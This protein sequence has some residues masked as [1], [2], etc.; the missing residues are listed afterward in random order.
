MIRKATETDIPR[1]AEIYDKT[2]DADRNSTSS[3]TG[4]IK[5]IYPSAATAKDAFSKDEL[6]VLEEDNVIFGAAIINKT[7]PPAY[8][9]ANWHY[10]D[11]ADNRIMVL[12]TLVIDPETKGKGFGTQFVRF[13]EDYAKKDGCLYLRIDTNEKN[14][15]ARRLYKYLGYSEIDIITGV[16][17][18]IPDVH[19]VCMEK[20]VQ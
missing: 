11:A 14:T 18:G 16:F 20:K 3:Q 7:Q 19:L 17:N 10:T 12:H 4:W 15:A 13:Y 9:K 2:I 6:F 5:G 1:I 8:A